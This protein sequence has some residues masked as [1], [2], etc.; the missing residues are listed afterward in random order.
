MG[1]Y[2]FT[3]AKSGLPVM[4]GE[5]FKEAK[6]TKVKVL[7]ANGDVIQG[8]Y[9]GYGRVDGESMGEDLSG[10]QSQDKSQDPK[11]VLAAYHC[12]EPFEALGVS[13]SDPAQ[14]FFIDAD[15]VQ[16][17]HA[18]QEG[19][20]GF[21]GH[22][23]NEYRIQLDEL[24]ERVCR[25]ESH[26]VGL[27]PHEIDA[28]WWSLESMGFLHPVNHGAQIEAF[29]RLWRENVSPRL[30]EGALGAIP[31]SSPL[32]LATPREA[33]QAIVTQRDALMKLCCEEV[34]AA[35]SESRRVRAPDFD[36]LMK[37]G[38]AWLDGDLPQ[39]DRHAR[40]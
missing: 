10:F 19:Q 31:T 27:D 12:G 18:L 38:E 9:D 39:P 15:F 24:G 11:I 7:Y 34:L 23:Y 4:A 36:G 3:C 37:G 29:D 33:V 40:P 2:S 21:D 30:E 17:M 1:F 14:G 8:T 28:L 32:R 13:E 25:F 20:P 6:F 35:W 26:Q 5:A 16:G 22:R